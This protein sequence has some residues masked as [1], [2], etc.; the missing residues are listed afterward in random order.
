MLLRVT[1]SLQHCY[2]IFKSA[3]F[4]IYGYPVGDKIN[5]TDGKIM[6]AISMNLIGSVFI[7]VFISL[8]II[9]PLNNPDTI[10][11]MKRYIIILETEI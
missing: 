6:T 8:M 2:I 4:H 11:P 7:Y 1:Q 3:S 10:M 5:Q 9:I